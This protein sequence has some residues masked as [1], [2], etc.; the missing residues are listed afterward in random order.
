ML[1]N[2]QAVGSSDLLRIPRRVPVSTL[3]TL[4]S[5]L[6]SR[7]PLFRIRN[8]LYLY[9]CLSVSQRLFVDDPCDLVCR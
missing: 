7:P 1:I 8:W 3:I 4:L 6:V 2:A 5:F 9:L